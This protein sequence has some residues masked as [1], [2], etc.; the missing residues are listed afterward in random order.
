MDLKIIPILDHPLLAEV[1]TTLLRKYP[2]WSFDL[3]TPGLAWHYT[4]LATKDKEKKIV[5]VC[6]NTLAVTERSA[7]LSKS[8]PETEPASSSGN[9]AM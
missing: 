8:A 2:G 7:T 3:L 4:F 5:C 1:K 9:T 6:E